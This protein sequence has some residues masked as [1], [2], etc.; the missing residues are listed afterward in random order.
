[1]G[2]RKRKTELSAKQKEVMELVVQGY[3]PISIAS[4]LFITESTV[5][6]HM[7][8]IYRKMGF[9][10]EK[11]RDM[12]VRAIMKYL[13]LKE[14]KEIKEIREAMEVL[15]GQYNGLLEQHKQLLREISFTN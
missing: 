9:H 3:T 10:Y 5:K 6:L 8:T 13:S 1:M 12:K 2:I 7:Q 11:G 4:M 15:K 14:I